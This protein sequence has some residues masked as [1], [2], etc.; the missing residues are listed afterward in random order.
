MRY[1][2][3]IAWEQ[4]SRGFW[5]RRKRSV[6]SLFSV[7]ALLA[8]VAVAFKLF[9]DPV[10]NNVA[11]DAAVFEF[12]VWKKDPDLGETSFQNTANGSPVFES[13]V[14]TL[15]GDT[16]TVDVKIAN[17]H[18]QP[19][20]DA[21]FFVYVDQDSFEVTG[22]HDADGKAMPVEAD[23]NGDEA[24]ADGSTTT[25]P[26]L[27]SPT[28]PAEAAWTRFVNLWEFEVE[29]QL[30]LQP[31][32][33]DLN[34]SDHLGQNL[35]NPD[36]DPDDSGNRRYGDVCDGGLRTITNL[37]PCDLGRVR[38]AGSRD[39]LGEATDQRY[40]LFHLTEIDDGSEQSVFKGWTLNF[41]LVFSARV[42]ALP[43]PGIER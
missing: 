3:P 40:Y 22:C 30:I 14:D 15:P 33:N 36:G 24:C 37:D 26:I 43:E 28:G 41:G 38:S 11:R 13:G 31:A 12:E 39:L 27:I 2:I 42:P 35:L 20:K 8:G 19:P 1:A 29:K 25:D 4:D 32:D 34:Q 10:P 17:V 21:T 18:E 5:T 9:D 6:M 16:R 7:V 23:E